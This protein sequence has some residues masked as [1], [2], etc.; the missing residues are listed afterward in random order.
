MGFSAHLSLS[1]AMECI[2]LQ[3]SY[4]IFVVVCNIQIFRIWKTLENAEKCSYK[5][6]KT[7]SFGEACG[8]GSDGGKRDDRGSGSETLW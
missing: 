8:G 1:D 7:L 3:K 5:L 6:G 4:R 2:R